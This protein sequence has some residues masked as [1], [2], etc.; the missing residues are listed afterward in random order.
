MAKKIKFPLS[1]KDDVQVRDLD[2]LKQYFDM[3]KAVAYFLD[4][5]LLAWLEA[6]YYDTEADA[7]RSLNKDDAD[8]HRRLCEILGVEYQ[9]EAMPE[10]DMEAVAERNRRLAELKQYTSDSTILDR[11]DQVAMNQEELA[12]VIDEGYSDIYLCNNSFVIPLRVRNKHYIGIGKAEAV[13]RSQEQ[14]DFEALGIR[15]ENVKFDGEYERLTHDLPKELYEKGLDAANKENYRVAMDYYKE[16]AKLGSAQ[17]M[18][19]I[20]E[21]YFFG[22][23]VEVDQQAAF[24]W[25]QKAAEAGWVPSMLDVA[26]CYKEG[27]GVTQSY[28]EAFFWYKTAAETG[29]VPKNRRAEAMSWVGWCYQ[30]GRGVSS[31]ETEAFNWYRKSAELE[32]PDGTHNLGWCYQNGYGVSQSDT[33]AFTWYKKAAELGQAS[34]MNQLG[35]CYQNG[36][37]TSIDYHLAHDWYEKAADAGNSN[38]M[39][40]LGLLYFDGL[41]VPCDYAIARAWFKKAVEAGNAATM[42]EIGRIYQNG[43]YG[44]QPDILFAKEWFEKAANAGHAE[45]KREFDI[46]NSMDPTAF[47]LARTSFFTKDFFEGT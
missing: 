15:F 36:I 41:G 12:D 5:K 20:S 19:E 38:G 7:I 27:I 10:I 45:A 46:I 29:D 35:W 42:Y 32:N 44:Y 34:A 18:E 28:Q 14:V 25:A 11:I 23:G 4:G 26:Y 1:M 31:S 3:D 24:S 33:Q 22:R 16:A 21:F 39:H 43:Y 30:N 13:I 40:N 6:R 9:A 8:V 2:E 17:S 47:L 37:G